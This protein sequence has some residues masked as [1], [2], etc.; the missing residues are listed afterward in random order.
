[1]SRQLDGKLKGGFFHSVVNDKFGNAVIV[2][3]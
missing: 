1:M 3:V 2:M